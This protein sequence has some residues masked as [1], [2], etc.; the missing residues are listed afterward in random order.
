MGLRLAISLIRIRSGRC[1]V[2]RFVDIGFR[3]HGDGSSTIP[4]TK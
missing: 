1:H 4:S 3:V 2:Q